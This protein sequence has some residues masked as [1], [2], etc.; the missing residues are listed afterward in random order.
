M[1]RDEEGDDKRKKK[2]IN[3][4]SD[5]KI[6]REQAHSTYEYERQCGRLNETGK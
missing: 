5:D 2:G 6:K 1:C 4:E 3:V